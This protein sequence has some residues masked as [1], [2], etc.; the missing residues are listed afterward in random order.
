MFKKLTYKQ[1][2]KFL[3]IGS[4]AFFILS[5]FVAISKTVDQVSQH[6]ELQ[7]KA[8]LSKKAPEEIKRYKEELQHIEQIFGNNTEDEFLFQDSLLAFVTPFCEHN[9][10]LVRSFPAP[11]KINASGFEIQTT[12]FVVEGSFIKLLRL[13]YELEQK[14]KV[15]RLAAVDFESEENKKT[16]QLRLKATLYLQNFKKLSENSD[17]N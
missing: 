5:Y 10:I 12:V 11:H 7:E 3:I 17:E 16:K 4:I 8:E 14:H 9:G 6:F 13:V 2:N 15:G 1:K